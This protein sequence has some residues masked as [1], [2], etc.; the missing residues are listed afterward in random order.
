M[1]NQE[2]RD[3]IE[4]SIPLRFQQKMFDIALEVDGFITKRYPLSRSTA[5]SEFLKRPADEVVATHDRNDIHWQI[6]FNSQGSIS[7]E[8]NIISKYGDKIW[9]IYLS[10]HGPFITAEFLPW[11]HFEPHRS[12]AWVLSPSREAPEMMAFC[13][14]IARTFGIYYVEYEDLISIKVDMSLDT[15]EMWRRLEFT[16]D[17]DVDAFKMLFHEY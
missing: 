14:E 3:L 1:I 12:P 4:K 13:D 6:C 10:L 8:S 17:W 15:T 11:K 9:D 2:L 16:P 7:A 5:Y